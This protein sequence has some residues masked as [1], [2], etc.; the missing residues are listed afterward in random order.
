M[1]ND[2]S[3][4]IET[5]EVKELLDD[6]Y[7]GQ[8]PAFEVQAFIGFFDK[9]NDGKISWSEFESGLGAAMAKRPENPFLKSLPESLYDDDEEEEEL[10][11]I[12]PDVSGEVSIELE[13]GEV[14]KVEAKEY[15]QSL[16]KEAEALKEALRRE[17]LGPQSSNNSVPG[18]APQV[19]DDFGGI[20]QYIASRQGDIKAL[21]EGI[22]PEIVETMKLLVDFVLEGGDSGKGKN[23]PKEEVEM[24]L[25]GSALQQLALW[26]LVLGY[27]LRE[28]EAT[29]EY[30]KLLE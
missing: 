16:K 11:D 3:G 2:N 15:I 22:Q 23:I 7:E 9:N 24:E 28:A 13:D 8:A 5:S 6:V 21:T 20:T 14:I 27:R 4:F 26:Q 18:M 19:K 25:P 1:D 12:E 10:I 30:L 17:K 29:G